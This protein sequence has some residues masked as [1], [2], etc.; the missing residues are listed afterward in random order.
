MVFCLSSADGRDDSDFSALG[1][2][3]EGFVVDVLVV[4]GEEEGE[5]FEL[6]KT[7]EEVFLSE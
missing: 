2:D 3:G 5:M 6:G 1:E 4:E 7:L